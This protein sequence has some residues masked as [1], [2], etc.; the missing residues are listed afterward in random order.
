MAYSSSKKPVKNIAYSHV[1]KDRCDLRGNN[2]WQTLARAW[3][4]SF[5]PKV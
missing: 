4:E 5:L 3:E 1:F 2:L